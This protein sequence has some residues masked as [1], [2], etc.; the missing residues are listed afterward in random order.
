[1]DAA[2][3]DRHILIKF[4]NKPLNRNYFN[5]FFKLCFQ[6]TTG[7]LRYLKVKGYHLPSKSE[8]IDNSLSDITMDILGSF[9]RSEPN[10][11]YVVIFDCF[12]KL[13]IKDYSQVDPK[14]LFSKFKSLLFG[15]IRQELSRIKKERDPQLYNLKRRIKDIVKQPEYS[16]F[17]DNGNHIE[18]VCLAVD[19][20]SNINNHQPIP[21]DE[22]LVL[23]EEAYFLSKNRNDWCLNVFKIL[24]ENGNMQNRLK[25]HEL[26]S[27][28]I[29]INL[30]YV[31]I[32]GVRPSR[33]SDANYQLCKNEV[34]DAK[35]QSLLWLKSDILQGFIQKEK[36][37]EIESQRFILAVDTYLTDLIY[38]SDVDLLPEYFRE[39]MPKTEHSR[40]LK[41]YKYVFETIIDKTE[42]NFRNRIKKSTKLFFGHYYRNKE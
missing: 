35:N 36:I 38:S 13:E 26:I 3:S 42:E 10:K 22:L 40:Y 37:T 7:Y 41:S 29:N 2:N 4:L 24:N 11:Q 27:A 1:M 17:K 32:D 31:E 30:K 34:E 9:L 6:M 19:N 23:T 39:V 20:T 15:F 28:M 12:E 8:T 21:Y 5:A 25:K 14:E 16:I 18:Y 33:L